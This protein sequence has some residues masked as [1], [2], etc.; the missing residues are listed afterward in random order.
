M[1]ARLTL[2]P[3]SPAPAA[4]A[5]SSSMSPLASTAGAA[6]TRTPGTRKPLTLS[7]SL[8][9]PK[10]T[11][12]PGPP[13]AGAFKKRKPKPTKFRRFYERGD[14]PIAVEHR[15]LGNRIRWMVEIEKLDYHHYL[16]TFFAGLSETQEPYRFLAYQGAIDLL[17][18]GGSK[19]VP[20]VPQL[21]LPIKAALNT[22][23]EEIVC[24]TLIMI[25]RLVLSA[26]DVGVALTPYFRQILPI[27]GLYKNK[28]LNL[29]DGIDYGQRFR[30]NVGDL[31]EETLQLLELNGGEAA[32]ININYIIPT[33][34]S[35][36]MN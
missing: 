36:V 4:A 11:R 19:I 20:V 21:V 5:A 26:P 29:G 9:K 32:Y 15:A 18:N 35:C 12:D 31:V 24:R 1:S 28:N 34:S 6:G 16:P 22:R 2:P 8:K 23:D 30:R 27:M 10:E 14:L 17:E 33:Y 25:Q 3:T 7:S 13:K